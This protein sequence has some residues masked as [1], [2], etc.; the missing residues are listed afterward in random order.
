MARV[1]HKLI[2]FFSASSSRDLA[3][4]WEWNANT[5]GERHADAY[6]NFLRGQTRNLAR[7]DAP[8]RAIPSN[9]TLRYHTL[10]RRAGGY[11]HVV[12][13]WIQGDILL[14]LRYFHTSQ[15]WENKL[16]GNPASEETNT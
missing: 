14:L 11:G 15:D 3:E 7:L 8:G 6:I 9:P 4:I 16:G 10:K 2:V 12:I 5:R 1:P 13:F